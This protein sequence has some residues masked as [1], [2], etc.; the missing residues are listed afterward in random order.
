[1]LLGDGWVVGRVVVGGVS[2]EV[3]LG[4]ALRCGMGR[5]PNGLARPAVAGHAHVDPDIGADATHRVDLEAGDVGDRADP[6]VR[7]D[8]GART[9][10]GGREVGDDL[11]DE[12]GA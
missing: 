8:G 1:M 12:P 9:E 7:H 4:R 10:Q 3:R 6:Q 5:I 11:V 2:R